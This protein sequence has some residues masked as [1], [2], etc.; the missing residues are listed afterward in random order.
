VSAPEFDFKAFDER[1]VKLGILSAELSEVIGVSAATIDK[2]RA[3]RSNPDAENRIRLRVLDDDHVAALAIERVRERQ[4]R[5]MQGEGVERAE[6]E[7][8]YGGGYEN[9]TGG[10]PS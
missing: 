9:A 3:G 6:V 2:W 1:L 7:V 10:S 5:S 8:P 4:T